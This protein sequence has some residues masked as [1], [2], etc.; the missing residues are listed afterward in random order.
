MPTTPKRPRNAKE[1]KVPRAVAKA[2]RKRKLGP[3]PSKRRVG[4][5]T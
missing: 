4:K 2:T 3:T 1:K 5:K